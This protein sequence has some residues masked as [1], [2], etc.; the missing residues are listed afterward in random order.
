MLFDG[1]RASV[2]QDSGTAATAALIFLP[3]DVAN[4]MKDDCIEAVAEAEAEATDGCCDSCFAKKVSMSD[5]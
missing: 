1:A 3:T 4:D 5:L 2:L